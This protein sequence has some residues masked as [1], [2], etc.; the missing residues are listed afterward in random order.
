MCVCAYV[1]SMRSGGSGLG[2]R[3]G[4]GDLIQSRMD[5]CQET[6]RHLSVRV[7]QEAELLTEIKRL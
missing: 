2:V 5:I 4:K 7:I 1:C 3:T 6:L